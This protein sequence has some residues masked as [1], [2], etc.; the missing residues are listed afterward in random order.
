M[1]ALGAS[2]SLQWQEARFQPGRGPGRPNQRRVWVEVAAEQQAALETFYGA[3]LA[4]EIGALGREPVDTQQ[5][6]RQRL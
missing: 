5:P 1:V 6:L 3:G 4:L 2:G